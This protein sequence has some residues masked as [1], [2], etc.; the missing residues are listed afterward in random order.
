MQQPNNQHTDNNPVGRF[1]V[2]V[3]SLIIHEKTGK[4]LV[5][6]RASTLDW[7]PNEWEITY[8]RIDQ[9]EDPESGLRREISEELG[10]TD[11]NIHKVIRVWHMYRGPRSAENDLI[12]ITFLCSTNTDTIQIS[13][14]HQ[15]YQWVTPQEAL[16]LIKVEGI[17]KDVALYLEEQ[18]KAA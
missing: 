1:M 5:T 12:G 6:Q 16:D 18:K 4:L 7:Q 13:N 17:R 2:A 14:E 8:G 3:G 11:L 9:H 15:Q 10:L